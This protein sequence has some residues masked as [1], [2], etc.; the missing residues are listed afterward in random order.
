MSE[1]GGEVCEWKVSGKVS[2]EVSGKVSRE[3]S[4]W[5]C[6]EVSREVSGWVCRVSGGECMDECGQVVR[7]SYRI[8]QGM[9]MYM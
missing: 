2:G 7:F 6:R 3:M 9:Y 4:G 8:F 1:W 5:V